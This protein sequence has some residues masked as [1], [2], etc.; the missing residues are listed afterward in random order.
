[1]KRVVVDPVTRIE[2]HL[3][4]EVSVD[5]ATG[6]VQDA[7]SSGTAWRGIE[8]V[9]KNRD[10]RDVW[11]FV[12]RICGVCTS[13][14][15]LA[16]LRAVEDALGIQ[17]PKNANYI[18]NI[19]HSCLDTHDHI[20]HFYHLHALD[21]V[22]PVE[23]LKADPKKTAE[24][25]QQVLDT[26][27]VS[28]LQPND[29][30][31]SSSAYPKEFPKGNATYYA[32]IQTKVKKI[33]E[34]GQLGIFSAQWWDHPDY[35]LLPPEVHLMA[36]SHYLTILDRQ[37][38][39]VTPHVIFG[40]KN[41]HPHYIVG[42]MPCSISMDDM[43]APVNAARLASVD[44][45][46]SL[47]KDLVNYFYLPDLLAI[48]HLY[49]KAGMVDG[50]GLAKKRVLAYGG[51]PD[52]AY[53][54]IKDGDFFKKALVRANGVVENFEL[55]WEKAT[56]TALEG[57][58][59]MNPDFLSE[60]IN[61]SWF[62]Y[63]NGETSLHP[64][65]GVTK[66]AFTGPKT[67]TNK[68]WE[69]LDEEKKYSWIKSPTFKGKACEVGPLAKYIV[70]YVKVKQGI[71]KDPTWAEKMMVDQIDAV[72]KVLGVPAHVWLCSTVGRTAA[73]GLDAQV[74]A[75]LS[76]HFYNRLV[77]NIKTGDTVVADTRKFDPNTWAKEAKGV[78]ILDAPRGGLGHWCVIKDGR[79]DNYQCIVPTTWNACPKTIAGEHGA[80]EAN[81]MDTKV[82]I[83]DK[84]LEILKGIHSFDPCLACATHLYNKKGEKI[85]SVNTDALCK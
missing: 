18:R 5:E 17:I 4:V 23:A 37:R 49:V 22:S 84:P 52:D 62:E 66:P 71:I 60:E 12:Q 15:A 42:G 20:V 67:G 27:N 25:Q 44:E 79:V 36:I 74:A 58:D 29:L 76:Q 53:T 78:G 77:E 73:R 33:V 26:Y 48:G 1:M 31:S 45:S 69:F 80:Y 34:S 82:K 13:T 10:P 56:F 16:A 61:H 46:I 24:L 85:V 41:P 51:Y 72:S 8:L 11:A 6:K 64:T 14:H 65:E 59:L 68:K 81:M 7:L 19:M 9:A 30:E 39:I 3:R 50:G 43:N 35:Q 75:N 54:G 63:P 55:G 32:A 57:E 47:A 83:A 28:G 21:W 38:D 40:G 70:V 2:G